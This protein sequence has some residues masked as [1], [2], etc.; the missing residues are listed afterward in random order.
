MH[1]SEIWILLDKLHF[2]FPVVF[3]RPDKE[4]NVVQQTAVYV[5]GALA[6]PVHNQSNVLTLIHKMISFICDLCQ[7]THTQDRKT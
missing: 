4:Y 6:I 2:L 7:T 3:R 5:C 1:F